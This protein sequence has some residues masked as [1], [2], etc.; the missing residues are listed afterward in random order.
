MNRKWH[1]VV[2]TGALLVLILLLGLA[3]QA[4]WSQAAAGSDATLSRLLRLPFMRRN[5]S[6][7]YDA[8]NHRLI[9]FGGWNGRQYFND[10]W[11]LDLGLGSQTWVQIRPSGAP[12]P[13]RAW[14]AAVVDTFH[15]RM[16]VV[17]G[18]GY[19]GD[20]GDAWAL[21]LTAGDEAWTE[22][23]PA[24]GFTPRRSMAADYWEGARDMYLFGGVSEGELLDEIVALHSDTVPGYESWDR[25]V[26]QGTRPT[27]RLG[28]TA[29]WDPDHERLIVF[30]GAD[31]NG[32]TNDV[33]SY[34]PYASPATWTLLTPPFP[35]RHLLL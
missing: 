16:L 6:L 9:L 11:A 31:E 32:N 8:A 35:Q 12:P 26:S 4:A 7:V 5:H 21:D 25:P 19:G 28:A 23:D 2:W 15:H 18:Q 13:P 10:V 34:Q 3:T 1:F 22:L 17:G 24:G 14:H 20:L 29:V 33:Y 30:G 27:A